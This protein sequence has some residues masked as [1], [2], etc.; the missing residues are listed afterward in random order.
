MNNGWTPFSHLFAD[1]RL[2][3]IPKV[4]VHMY[5]KFYKNRF[6]LVLENTSAFNTTDKKIPQHKSFILIYGAQFQRAK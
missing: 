5:S 4:T 6:K 3:M 1:S 2:L